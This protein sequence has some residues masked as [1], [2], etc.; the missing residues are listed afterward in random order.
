MAATFI[1]MPVGYMYLVAIIDWFSRNVLAWRLSNTGNP[2][3][4]K[5]HGSGMPV[6]Q[7][8]LH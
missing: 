3:I 2:C 5:E 4:F 6:H 1:P 8:R 7:Q